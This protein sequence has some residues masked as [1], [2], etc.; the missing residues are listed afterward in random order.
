[1]VL[2]GQ[3]L[4]AIIQQS[5]DDAL[6]WKNHPKFCDNNALKASALV[7]NLGRS[8]CELLKTHDI[9]LNVVTVDGEGHKKPGE[10]LLDIVITKNDSNGFRKQIVW[11]IESETD[12]GLKPFC[13]DF[14]KLVHV[15]SENYL[16]MN[17]LNHKTTKG[18]DEYV[19]NRLKYATSV[20]TKMDI[21]FLYLGFWASPC[22]PDNDVVYSIWDELP[23]GRFQHLRK[24][25]LYFYQDGHFTEIV[26]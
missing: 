15:K 7:S 16:Y 5:F 18:R 10:W 19:A 13:D 12:T 14:A 6:N 9:T 11:A 20:L 26:S 2:R 24:I 1:M 4:K 25:L 17:G 21:Q 8:L 23:S 3:E 22:K